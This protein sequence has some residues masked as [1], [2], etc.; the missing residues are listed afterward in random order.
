MGHTVAL[1]FPHRP[2]SG[3]KSHSRCGIQALL[4]EITRLMCLFP[5]QRGEQAVWMGPGT[6]GSKDQV[7]KT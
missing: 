5:E 4:L 6:P 1:T 2:H 7:A 3:A